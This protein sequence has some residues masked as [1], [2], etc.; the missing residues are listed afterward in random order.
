MPFV[1]TSSSLWSSFILLLV[2]IQIPRYHL[3]K[4]SPFSSAGS[5]YFCQSSIY[6]WSDFWNF[7]SVP[8]VYVFF[9]NANWFDYNSFVVGFEIRLYYASHFALLIQE[10]FGHCICSSI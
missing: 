7:Y 6:V 4:K 10:G 2:D 1:S 3:L 5:Q 8:F 9:L